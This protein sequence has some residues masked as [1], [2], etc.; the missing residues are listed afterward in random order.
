MGRMIEGQSRHRPAG[1]F[2]LVELLVV[3]AVVALLVS[4]LLP[5]L[6]RSREVARRVQCQAN[7]RSLHQTLMIY[8][9]EHDQKVP[10]GY[11][12]GRL[13]WNTMV[14]SGFG[15]GT[16]ALFGRLYLADMLEAPE[17]LYCPSESA[18]EQSYDTPEN[19]WP[20]GTPGIGVQGGYA[21][22]PLVDWGFGSLP[23][24]MP[25]L[26]RLAPNRA[27][28]SDGIGLPDRVDSRHEQG[29]HVL[30]VDAAITWVDRRIFDDPLSTCEGLDPVNNAA[31]LEV[32]EAIEST[33]RRPTSRE[34]S[35]SLRRG[36]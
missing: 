11:R 6:T 3:I 35:R 10:L 36:W 2:T 13:Q 9:Q 8:A 26:D 22:A 31:Q 19:P 21:S 5:A 28:L 17:A 7:L 29:V 24:V 14:Y 25:R 30:F 33:R 18:P 34:S 27:L 15:S 4:L 23:D 1:G 16:F 32:W 12:G 20:P